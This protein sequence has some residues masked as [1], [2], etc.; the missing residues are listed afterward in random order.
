MKILLLFLS[1]CCW[2]QTSEV[3]PKFTKNTILVGSK[4]ITVE[5]ADNDRERAFGLMKVKNLPKDNGML[6]VFEKADFQ[7]FWM[8]NTEIPL[9][10]G[11]FDENNILIEVLEM[12]TESLVAKTLKSYPSSKPVKYALEMNKGWYTSNK[13]GPGAKL[14]IPK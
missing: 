6:F 10:I 8:K 5:V 4:K 3:R 14:S 1:F 13:I 9:S 7:S 2:A 11:Y 12:E